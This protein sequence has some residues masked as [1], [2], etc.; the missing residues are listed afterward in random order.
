MR[1][2]RRKGRPQRMMKREARK[3]RGMMIK[4]NIQKEQFFL[5]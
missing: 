3:G 5:V 4:N 1:K 2:T